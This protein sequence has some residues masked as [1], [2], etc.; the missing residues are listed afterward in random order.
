[1]SSVPALFE[2]S[3]WFERLLLPSA[4]V[5]VLPLVASAPPPSPPSAAVEPLLEE[6]VLGPAMDPEDEDPVTPPVL[7]LF[8]ACRQTKGMKTT[9]KVDNSRLT[10]GHFFVFVV[11]DGVLELLF[12]LASVIGLHAVVVVVKVVAAAVVQDI[13]KL[14]VLHTVA[15]AHH[16]D[17]LADLVE[18]KEKNAA[19]YVRTA[20]VLLSVLLAKLNRTS[21]AR[22]QPNLISSHAIIGPTFTKSAGFTKL[23]MRG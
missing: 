21:K 5:K 15:T 19:I 2:L 4:V 22:V 23:I 14:G 12:V 16:L 17:E 10:I 18:K 9:Q 11:F 7:L 8:P 13:G 6:E 1:M 3:W 20:E